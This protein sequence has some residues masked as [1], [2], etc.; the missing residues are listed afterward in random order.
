M[1]LTFMLSVE[2]VRLEKE[3]KE[4]SAAWVTAIKLF[5]MAADGIKTMKS[6]FPFC[7]ILFFLAILFLIITWLWFPVLQLFLYPNDMWTFFFFFLNI[8]GKDG[9]VARLYS[10]MFHCSLPKCWKKVLINVLSGDFLNCFLSVNYEK[11]IIVIVSTP[12]LAPLVSSP[13]SICAE[14][15]PY[16]AS[17]QATARRLKWESYPA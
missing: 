1:I 11:V 14:M 16:I 3:L 4:G 9:R 17:N 7:F 15:L 10:L 13:S 12:C 2:C 8:R 5:D 6:L